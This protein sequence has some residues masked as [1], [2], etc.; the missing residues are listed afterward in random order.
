MEQW[1]DIAEWRIAEAPEVL[2]SR[3]LGS[4]LAVCLYAPARQLGAL[5]HLLLPKRSDA[6]TAAPESRYVDSGI[7]QMRQALL[8]RGVEPENLVAKMA[9]GANLFEIQDQTLLG[10]I[11]ARNIRS[12]RQTLALLQIGLLA[13]DVGG[14]RERSVAFDLASGALIVYCARDD[15][16]VV[17]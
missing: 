17:L 3:G 9:G 10:G 5:G 6:R 12:A 7:R 2:Q 11:G 4:C 13:E 8:A 14:N 1:I 15:R 16:K